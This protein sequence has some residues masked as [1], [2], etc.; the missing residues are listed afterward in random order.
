M[1]EFCFSFKKSVLFN[2]QKLSALPPSSM[3]LLDKGSRER[4]AQ[5]IAVRRTALD[6]ASRGGGKAESLMPHATILSA[7][8]VG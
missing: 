4:E 3:R 5:L 8:T 1:K 7:R 6:G 2:E